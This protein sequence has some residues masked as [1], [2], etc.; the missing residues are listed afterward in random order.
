MSP[1]EP[2]V[3]FDD[4]YS[5]F[6][7]PSPNNTIECVKDGFEH[8]CT[9]SASYVN[10]PVTALNPDPNG[11]FTVTSYTAPVSA[12]VTAADQVWVAPA[13]MT[14]YPFSLHVNSLSFFVMLS[15]PS[16]VE[17]L[18]VIVIAR[19]S[20]SQSSSKPT[21]GSHVSTDVMVVIRLVD[22]HDAPSLSFVEIAEPTLV[23]VGE[24]PF[25]SHSARIPSLRTSS[26]AEAV[27]PVA[28]YEAAAPQPFDE[29]KLNPLNDVL[30]AVAEPSSAYNTDLFPLFSSIPTPM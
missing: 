19:A 27:E 5:V 30:S 28:S 24:P 9:Q 20:L 3:W 25:Q 29:S 23:N 18:F 15:S 7:P 21:V 17:P 8:D 13:S 10:D 2:N 4:T 11:G 1:A 26:T 22:P 6:D 16:T 14:G 12:S